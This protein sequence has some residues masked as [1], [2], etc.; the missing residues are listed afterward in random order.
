MVV[1]ADTHSQPHPAMAD[2]IRAEA[3]AAILHAGDVGDA[4]VL[5]ALARLAPL[6]AVRGNIDGRSLAPDHI[7]LDVTRATGPSLRILLTHIAVRGP[8]LQAQAAR[9]AREEGASVV[10]CGHSHV[11]LIARD[12]GLVVFNPGSVGPRRFALPIT[13][14]VLDFSPRGVAMRH[15]DCETGARWL[16]P[17]AAA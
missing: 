11:P 15:L 12:Q 14:G 8:R 5:D 10:I 1:V 17:G 6:V 2:L 16:P 9:L 4:A 3:P 13:L 7:V